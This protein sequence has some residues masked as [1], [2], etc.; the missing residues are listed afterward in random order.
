MWGP[1]QEDGG[2]FLGFSFWLI[3]SRLGAEKT[4]NLE[5][6]LA[7]TTKA[8]QK[9]V[10]SGQ[11]L[12]RE[13]PHKIVNFWIITALLQPNTT[14]KNCSLLHPPPLPTQGEREA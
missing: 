5:T 7:Q 4:G 8:Q 11:S 3:Y 2:G 6:P 9:S 14:E 1:N 10:V 13:Q 12:G